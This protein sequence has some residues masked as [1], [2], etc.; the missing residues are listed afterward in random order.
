MDVTFI[1]AA[2][3]SGMLTFLAPCTLPLLPAYVSFISGASVKDLQKNKFNK[4]KVLRNGLLYV[5]GFSLVFIFL[6]SA[7]GLLGQAFRGWQGILTRVGGVMII[8]FG[9]YLLHAFDH[10]WFDFLRKDTRKFHVDKLKP[11][12]PLS[13][14]L[15]GTFFAFGWT[16]CIGPVLGVVLTL[17]AT[18]ASVGTGIL[19][20]SVFSFGLAIPFLVSA[21]L[22]GHLLEVLKKLHK[23]L[24]IISVIGGILLFLLG[25]AMLFDQFGLWTRFFYQ[26]FNFINYD[27]LLDYL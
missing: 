16:P 2:F 10:R 5:L 7:F 21:L 6:G 1:I 3:V 25:V 15:F 17:A 11:G 8:V 12:T 14:F 20:L 18:K 23:A 22:I 19:L 4:A 24:N 9:L 13:S 27:A 26:L